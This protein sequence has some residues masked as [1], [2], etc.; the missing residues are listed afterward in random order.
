MP[1]GNKDILISRYSDANSYLN[2]IEPDKIKELG[3]QISD[4]IYQITDITP[5]AEAKNAPA[6][7]RGIWCDKVYYKLIPY[8]KG[9]SD[10]EKS[11]RRD[12]ADKADKLLKEIAN[13]DVVIKDASGAAIITDNAP[14]SIIS[15][16]RI[17]GVL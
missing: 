4:E 8:Q 16:K 15:T 11:R 13:G 10:E 9:L 14:I 3:E 7:L 1:F 2:D 6:I 12:I 5:P 17:N